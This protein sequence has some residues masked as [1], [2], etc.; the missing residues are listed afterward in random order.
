MRVIDD[1]PDQR[2][3]NLIIESRYPKTILTTLICQKLKDI[4]GFDQCIKFNTAI[5]NNLGPWCSDRLWQ[6]I[7][8]NPWFQT[9]DKKSDNNMVYSRKYSSNENQLLKEARQ[10]CE[11]ASSEPDINNDHLFTPKIRELINC[12][13][14]IHKQETFHGIIFVERRQVAKAIKVL[15]ESLSVFKDSIRCDILVGHGGLNNAPGTVNMKLGDQHSIIQKFR[16]GELNLIVATSVAE[17]GLDIQASAYIQSRG[18]ARRREARYIL[19][20]NEQNKKET[21]LILHFQQVEKNM[22]DFCRALPEERNVARLF[23]QE[24]DP[25]FIKQQESE[26]HLKNAYEIPSTGAILTVGSAIALVYDYCASLPSDAFCN[27]KPVY[28]MGVHALSGNYCVLTLPIN[29][30]KRLFEAFASSKLEAKMAVSLEACIALHKLGAIDDNLVPANKRIKKRLAEEVDEEGKQIG[31]RKRENVYPKKIPSFWKSPDPTIGT[32]L[33]P[34]WITYIETINDSKFRKMCLITRSPLPPIEDIEFNNTHLVKL[35]RLK[36]QFMFQKREQVE[37][38]SSYVIAITRAVTNKEFTCSIDNTP[39]FLAPL[40]STGSFDWTEI[41]RTINNKNMPIDDDDD[42]SKLQDTIAID[43]SGKY[44]FVDNVERDIL[45]NSIMKDDTTFAQYF[46]TKQDIEI[47]NLQQPLLSATRINKSEEP[48]TSEISQFLIPE[49]CH[50]YSISASVFRVLHV[51]PAITAHIDATLLALDAKK[52]LNLHH[53][54]TTLMIEAYAASSA[55]IKINYQR[56]EFLG[57]LELK[58]YHY[59]CSQTLPR[60]FWRPHGFTTASD[61]EQITKV[62][63]FHK[64]AD[65]TLADVIE[66]TLGAA[67]LTDTTSSLKMSLQAARQLQVPLETVQL[68]SDFNQLFEIEKIQCSYDPSLRECSIERVTEIVGHDF[69]NKGLIVEALTHAS[70]PVSSVPCYQRLEFLG[71]AVLDFCVTDY[72]FE[73]YGTAPP[74]LL[75]NLRK[76]SV[77]NDILSVLCVQL[78]LH[79]HIR[80]GSS[81]LME[82]ILQFVQLVQ[83]STEKQGEYWLDFNPPKV[84]SDVIESLI[85]AVYVDCQFRLEP[86]LKL[87]GRWLKPLLENHISLQSIQEHPVGKLKYFVQAYGCVQCETRN[88]TQNASGPKKCVV[89]IHQKPFTSGSGFNTREARKE[90]ATRA[91]ELLQEDENLLPSLCTCK[92]S[93][94]F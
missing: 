5:S 20:V 9:Q 11:I 61:S 2:N 68:W 80:H 92:Q 84:L 22:K 64:L 78:K 21:E 37:R 91:Y 60:R 57:A 87:F 18:R 46:K 55:G 52:S 58:R 44:Y 85:G 74:G 8:D 14:A 75:H 63:N 7:L 19:M 40:K 43:P 54:D 41:K 39:Y 51:F 32:L 76:S 79:T 77:N 94:D 82:S 53:V 72:L 88:I 59:I 35:E 27:F 4:R 50:I 34:Y 47:R 24:Y 83:D 3:H 31:S 73:K 12:L 25:D 67:Y 66:S 29:S 93:V 6:D 15:I 81:Y 86:V 56:L 36:T 48:G 28:K 70:V 62:I 16:T 23:D 17:E 65:K 1:L 69:K 42:M 90:A 33:G 71:D 89:F 13:T 26:K 45:P 10:L 49:L 38:L 30:E